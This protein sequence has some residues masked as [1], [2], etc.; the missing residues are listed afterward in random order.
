MKFFSCSLKIYVLVCPNSERNYFFISA[1]NLQLCYLWIKAICLL[2]FRFSETFISFD[3]I[4][5]YQELFY[6]FQKLMKLTIE[7]KVTL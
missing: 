3:D 6:S 2:L 5:E 4:V 7:N 1:V